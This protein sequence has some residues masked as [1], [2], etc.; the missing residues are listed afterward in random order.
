MSRYAGGANVERE[1]IHHLLKKGYACM[2]AAGSGKTSYPS[3]DIFAGKHGK[4]L[5]IEVKSSKKDVVYIEKN[6]IDELLRWASIA[7]CIPIVAVKFKNKGW[8]FFNNFEK[9]SDKFYAFSFDKG[10]EVF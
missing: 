10:E 7:Q 4:M 8:K 1:L 6:E 5:A 2:R 3:P 9:V